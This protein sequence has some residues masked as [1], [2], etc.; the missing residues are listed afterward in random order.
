MTT[1]MFLC[2]FSG[3]NANHLRSFRYQSLF[4]VEPWQSLDLSILEGFGVDFD[5]KIIAQEKFDLLK[6]SPIQL[7]IID[8]LALISVD[9][10]EWQDTITA[11]KVSTHWW[12]SILNTDIKNNKSLYALLSLILQSYAIKSLSLIHI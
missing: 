2:D 8:T 11:S 4:D 12:E 3:I 10:N 5:L 1:N 9:N 7:T 6:H